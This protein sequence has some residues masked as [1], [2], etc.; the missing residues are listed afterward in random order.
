MLKSTR[1]FILR[2]SILGAAAVVFWS[3]LVSASSVRA[4]VSD[5]L[6]TGPATDREELIPL[7]RVPNYRDLMR[8]IVEEFSRY[9]QTRDP[10][11]AIVVRPGFE[12]LR[13]DQREVIL[14]E[15]KRPNVANVPDD[16]MTP[17]GDPMRRYIQAIDAIALSNQFYGAGGVPLAA[18][19][20]F[21]DMGVKAMSVEHCGS[22]AAAV[23]ALER[24]AAAGMPA[25]AD[26]E[27]D[28]TFEEIPVRR[29][30]KENAN[31][32][33]AIDDAQNLLIV[34]ENKSYGSRGD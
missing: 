9:A 7:A 16:A 18:L 15:A 28:D 3:I 1:Q 12:L 24:A 29:P 20:R 19:A 31:N 25:H 5:L 11:F 14:S 34:L 10:S 26:A 13:W 17:L 33:E 6:L 22:D 8:E 32:I 4:Q 2:P 21:M 27:R 23:Q 30:V